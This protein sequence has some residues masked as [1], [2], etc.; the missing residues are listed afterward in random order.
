MYV[1]FADVRFDAHYELKSDIV[2]G[3]KCAQKAAL[4][5]SHNWPAETLELTM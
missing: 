4:E 1:A 2:S 3:A 5:L